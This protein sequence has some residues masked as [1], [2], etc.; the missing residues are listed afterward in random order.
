[1][2]LL[3]LTLLLKFDKLLTAPIAGWKDAHEYRDQASSAPYLPD[4][5]VPLLCIN[6]EDDPIISPLLWPSLQV[7]PLFFAVN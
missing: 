5:R 1:M 7:S 4:V 3:T 6:A 2:M